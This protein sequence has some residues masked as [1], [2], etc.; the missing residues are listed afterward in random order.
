MSASTSS[1][2]WSMAAAK[3]SKRSR[4]LSA[5]WRHC[6]RAASWFSWANTV[7]MAAAT[8]RGR[9]AG[10]PREGPDGWARRGPADCAGRQSDS[11]ARSRSTPWQRPLSALHGVRVDR[12][13]WWAAAVARTR[14]RASRRAGRGAWASAE[15]RSRWVRLP[16]GC[17]DPTAPHGEGSDRQAEDLAP[18][19]GVDGHGEYHGDRDDPAALPD[20]HMG[21][22]DPEVGPIALDRA[23]EEGLDTLVDLGPELRDLAPTGPAWPDPWTSLLMPVIPPGHRPAS[24][25]SADGAVRGP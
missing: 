15:R 3:R 16:V 12:G 1:S 13:P 22:V 21:R 18:A 23:V 25:P 24:C 11:V 7:P 2:A 17:G 8:R 5:T 14:P 10:R 4:R 20:L 9:G 19:V 6:A